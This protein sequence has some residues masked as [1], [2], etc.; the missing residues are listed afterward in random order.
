MAS[1]QVVCSVYD[2]GTNS[3]ANPF[4]V[5]HKQLALRSF[6]AE[7]NRPPH[8]SAIAATPD[9]FEL[10]QLALFDPDNGTFTEDKQVL[11]TA[12]SLIQAPE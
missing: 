10:H 11:A 2:R 1:F 9:D 8:E 3:Y 6:K 7:C 12:A 4:V 5:A